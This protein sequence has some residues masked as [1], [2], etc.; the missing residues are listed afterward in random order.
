MIGFFFWKR[1]FLFNLKFKIFSTEN[2]RFFF[3]SFTHVFL[4]TKQDSFRHAYSNRWFI[5]KMLKMIMRLLWLAMK[6]PQ[7]SSDAS[8]VRHVSKNTFKGLYRCMIVWV[9][10]IEN[11]NFFF[12]AF[13]FNAGK[14]KL[15]NQIVYD[16]N[17]RKYNFN[18]IHSLEDALHIVIVIDCL[19]WP[20]WIVGICWFF[21]WNWKF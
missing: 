18:N 12:S 21:F 7:R 14:Y 1:Q 5:M 11:N 2:D 13:I 6:R 16:T 3:P 4:L 19:I 8:L 20:K 17:C 10:L 15:S 9:F